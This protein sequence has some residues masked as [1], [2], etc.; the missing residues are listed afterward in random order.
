MVDQFGV[1][2]PDRLARTG[3][4]QVGEFLALVRR[5]DEAIDLQERLSANRKL[6]AQA[7]V[8]LGIF[9][10]RRHAEHLRSGIPVAVCPGCLGNGCRHCEDAGFLSAERWNAMPEMYRREHLTQHAIGPPEKAQSPAT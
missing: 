7:H 8:K 2:V 1:P 9:D 3:F 4:G 5:L 10:L 6:L